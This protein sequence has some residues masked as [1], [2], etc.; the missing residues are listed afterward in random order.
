M[1]KTG[2]TQ[3]LIRI[4]DNDNAG[5]IPEAF[6]NKAEEMKLWKIKRRKYRDYQ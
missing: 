6:Q 3:D 2:L 5:I 1:N 4:F